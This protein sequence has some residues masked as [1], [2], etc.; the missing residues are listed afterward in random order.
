MDEIIIKIDEKD[1]IIFF[2]VSYLF[3]EVRGC[4]L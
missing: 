3:L 2:Q 4:F 1:R